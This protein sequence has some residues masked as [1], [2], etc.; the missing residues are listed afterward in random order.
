MLFRRFLALVLIA[1]LLC[2][3]DA[4]AW[5]RSRR[6]KA[7]SWHGLTAMSALLLNASNNH[8]YFA[9]DIDRQIYPASTTKVMTVILALE[10]LSL[11]EYVTVSARAVQVPPTKLDLRPGE[12]YRV[13]DLIYAALLKSANDAANVL[14]EAV[15]G[16]QSQFVVLMNQ[17]AAQI[18]VRHT[19]FANA[20]GLPSEGTQYSTARDMAMIL[21]EALKNPFFKSAITFKYRIIYSKEGRR[22]FLKSHNKSLFMDWKMNVYGKTGYTQEAQSCFVG[23]YLKNKDTYVVAVF[24][25]HKRWEET[26]RIV[27]R[28]GKT[29]L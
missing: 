18:G 29:D 20:H 22:H 16:S 10:H 24:G 3:A 5:H 23:Y 15:A 4:S 17:K 9:K 26:K 14:A 7:S 2:P 11:D 27:E 1:V 8:Y 13:R 6:A 25:S 12:Q 21:K 28:Y 19:R